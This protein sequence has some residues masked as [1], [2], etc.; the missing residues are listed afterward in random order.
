MRHSLLAAAAGFACA[1]SLGAGA[2]S[3]EQTAATESAV[4]I[5]AVAEGDLGDAAR[6]AELARRSEVLTHTLK[7]QLE[8]QGLYR[9]VASDPAKAPLA[10]FSGRNELHACGPCLQEVA[11][12]LGASRVF[13]SWVF[14][15]SNLV[16]TLHTQVRDAKTSGVVWQRTL[17]FRGDNDQAWERATNYL[18]R[19]L[20]ETPAD[21]R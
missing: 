19:E 11:Q 15:M 16:L 20:R 7:T 3:A 14:R 9:V 13:S 21:K 2:A 1:L 4:V 5:D 10:R 12:T 8:A 6:A 18:L 17:S